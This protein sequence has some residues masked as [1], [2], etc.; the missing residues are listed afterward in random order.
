MKINPV[1][2]YSNI[3]KADKVRKTDD[4]TKKGNA[5]NDQVQISDAAKAIDKLIQKAK[6]SDVDRTAKVE[7]LK[8]QIENGTYKV[9][10]QKLASKIIDSLKDE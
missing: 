2:P 3:S 8:Q 4:V 6:S 1:N 5:V 7:A 10:S 9:D